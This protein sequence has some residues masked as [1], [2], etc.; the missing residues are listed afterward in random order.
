MCPEVLVA[1]NPV[2]PAPV[3]T[4]AFKLQPIAVEGILIPK[5]HG[6]SCLG[7]RNGID[8]KFKNSTGGSAAF[9]K[10]FVHTKQLVAGQSRVI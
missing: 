9:D 8:D 7:T 1:A 4:W 2:F 5:N 3:P 10:I 6:F